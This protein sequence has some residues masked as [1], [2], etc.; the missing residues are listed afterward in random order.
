M[1]C[2]QSTPD[3]TTEAEVMFSTT[4]AILLLLSPFFSSVH[5]QP[6]LDQTT[7]EPNDSGTVHDDSIRT[8][9]ADLKDSILNRPVVRQKVSPAVSLPPDQDTVVVNVTMKLNSVLNVDDMQQTMTSSLLFLIVWRDS[10]LSWSPDNCS[11]VTMIDLGL[12]SVWTPYIFL[13]NSPVVKNDLL[14]HAHH[15]S[16][17]NDGTVSARAIITVDTVCSMDHSQFPYDTQF[18]PIA[19]TTFKGK[20]SVNM[21]STLMDPHVSSAM[22][23]RFNWELVSVKQIMINYHSENYRIPAMQ[24]GLRRRTTFYTVCLVTP[25][26]LT[27][28][29]NTLVFLVPL[30]SGEKVSFLITLLVST[31]VYTSFFTEAM[32]RS[33]D[34]VPSTMK[35]L[36][37]VMAESLVI[38]LATLFIM[39]RFHSK[40]DQ[41][42]RP[43]SRFE[44]FWQTC[45]R[46]SVHRQGGSIVSEKG[47]PRVTKVAPIEEM[48]GR[49]EEVLAG[50]AEDTRKAAVSAESMDLMFFVLTFV[51]NTI[52]LCV[53]F[54]ESSL[55][56]G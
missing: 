10:S 44:S 9:V 50:A 39:R 23:Q 25:M 38:L 18:C 7:G 43:G 28:Y 45:S 41:A 37:W 42:G 5:G 40:Q 3:F 35:L 2:F 21:F 19:V 6:A 47:V 54:S 52:C 20:V 22:I 49:G 33:L 36:L 30:Q 11:G 16:V 51:A 8:A 17:S 31:S 27:S 26:V 34:S 32:P 29:T 24:V 15:L 46:G 1:G 12:D 14:S 4:V 48:A 56:A 13:V 53:L 55:I